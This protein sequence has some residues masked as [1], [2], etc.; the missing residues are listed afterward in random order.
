MP[1]MMF[2]PERVVMTKWESEFCRGA[3]QAPKPRASIREFQQCRHASQ[4]IAAV[5]A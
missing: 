3:H 1:V 5:V 4:L 2:D